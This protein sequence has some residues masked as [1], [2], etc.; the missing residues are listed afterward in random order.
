MKSPEQC[1]SSAVD[2]GCSAFMFSET[3]PSWGCRCC[4]SMEGLTD[5]NLWDVYSTKHYSKG[6]E[7]STGGQPDMLPKHSCEG[8]VQG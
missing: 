7:D 5:H 6:K 2:A 4:K 8:S 1:S 3:Y